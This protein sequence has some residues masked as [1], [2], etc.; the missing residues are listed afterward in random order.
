MQINDLDI[1]PL[2]LP[3]R[4]AQ[5]TPVS[6]LDP[7]SRPLRF[8]LNTLDA[9]LRYL[10]DCCRYGSTEV[11]K[12]KVAKEKGQRLPFEDIHMQR[13]VNRLWSWKAELVRKTGP[14][15]SGVAHDKVVQG[16]AEYLEVNRLSIPDD[17][18]REI[19]GKLAKLEW[20]IA[21][22]ADMIGTLQL[23]YEQVFNDFGS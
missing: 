14:H 21:A 11:R 2:R 18:G 15:M 1:G 13:L 23:E 7:V 9:D 17:Y 6:S 4:P 16:I 22:V 10:K 8:E 5:H 3:P 19:K 12:A 20:G